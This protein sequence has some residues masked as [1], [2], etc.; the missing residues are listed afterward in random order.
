MN[1]L[2]NGV[3]RLGACTEMQ[4]EHEKH[5]RRILLAVTGNSPQIV[6]ETL[7]ALA[8][9][10][11]PT[12]IPTEIHVISTSIGLDAVRDSLLAPQTG[13]FHRLLAEYDLPASI[14]FDE[15]TL[16]VIVDGAGQPLPDINSLA[17]NRAA[18]DQILDLVRQ[19]AS[20]E[21]CAIHAS[22]AGGRKTMGFFMGYAMSLLGRDQDA[23]SH[24]LVTEPFEKCPG[25]YYPPRQSRD[26]ETHSGQSVSSAQ[27]KV[28]LAEIPFLRMA[29]SI[30]LQKIK[31]GDSYS[32]AVQ[33]LQDDINPPRLELDL[34]A[35][36]AYAHRRPVHMSDSN[37]AL[38]TLFAVRN[39]LERKAFQLSGNE[40][41]FV[42]QMLEVVKAMD[43][44][45]VDSWTELAL[46][47]ESEEVRRAIE[48]R[49]RSTCTRVKD[50]LET[51]LG[52]L[53]TKYRI[54]K[55]R[56][57]GSPYVL[58]LDANQIQIRCEGFEQLV[59]NIRAELEPLPAEQ[60]EQ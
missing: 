11:A 28:M 2:Q 18:A 4:T 26:F 55:D 16:H 58:P 44:G 35:R 39:K 42:A 36:K 37:L 32:Q 53:A 24:V 34:D 57:R 10:Q 59:D 14:R 41:E 51:G 48:T 45:L 1:P 29:E 23:L 3:I 5:P 12:F 9:E 13:H 33:R 17:D 30:T 22:I 20:D 8:V 15:S 43:I 52:E 60:G 21:N 25:F 27:A 6:T 49:F 31:S 56:S 38:L 46:K 50:D 54:T 19:L 40:F 47:N 7:Y